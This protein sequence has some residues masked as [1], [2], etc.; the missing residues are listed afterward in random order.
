[1]TVW[2]RICPGIK[3]ADAVVFAAVA[4]TLAVF[5]VERVV[6]NGTPVIPVVSQTNNALR[7][8][9]YLT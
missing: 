9:L 3:A 7:S 2:C 1:M 4:S 6:E 8:V 5:N